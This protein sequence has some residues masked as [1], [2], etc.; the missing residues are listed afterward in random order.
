MYLKMW[1]RIIVNNLKDTF[2][3]INNINNI[4]VKTKF[5]VLSV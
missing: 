5:Y 4:Q 3:I 1:S 2:S